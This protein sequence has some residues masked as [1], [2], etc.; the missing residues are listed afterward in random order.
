MLVE[1]YP[2]PDY[3]RAIVSD[4]QA[5]VDAWPG[6][7]AKRSR[8]D[9]EFCFTGFRNGVPRRI[10]GSSQQEKEYVQGQGS[11]TWIGCFVSL[12][13]CGP[14]NQLVKVSS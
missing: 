7:C 14:P 3:K 10:P 6:T 1:G 11:A 5:I 8:L 2:E 13:T 4:K 9:A 12:C